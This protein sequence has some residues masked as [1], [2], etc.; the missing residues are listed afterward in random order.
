MPGSRVFVVAEY[1]KLT[2][3]YQFASSKIDQVYILRKQQNYDREIRLQEGFQ[4]N[5][6]HEDLVIDLYRQVVDYLGMAEE[7]QLN[8]DRKRQ[9]ALAVQTRRSWAPYR[10]RIYLPKLHACPMFT[11][12]TG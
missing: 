11:N 5:P 1:L 7:V 6:I 9:I 12:L 2:E 3:D 4:R 10:S 8:L